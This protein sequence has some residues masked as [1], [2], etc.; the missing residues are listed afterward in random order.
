MA[1]FDISMDINKD[2]MVYKNKEEK[3]PV[4]YQ[5]SN[6]K[7]NGHYETEL[8]MNLHTGTHIDAPL[9]MLENAETMSCY[10][11]DSFI[12][13]AKVL[14]LTHINGAISKEHLEK[15]TITSGDFILLKTKNSFESAFNQEFVF[16]DV[17]GAKYLAEKNISG[18]GIDAL[19]IERSQ[20]EHDT[21]IELM[22]KKIMILEG[23]RL[24]GIAEGEYVLLVLPIKLNGMEAAPARALL[25]DKEH[26]DIIA[27]MIK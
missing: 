20:P 8:K 27:N 9:H 21:H 16:L 18:V 13:K 22:N 17:T 12:R 10:S 2:M 4:F 6:H 19:G 7:E 5:A 11:P 3:K 15:H 14:E 24:E 23:I 25:I 1:I 26:I